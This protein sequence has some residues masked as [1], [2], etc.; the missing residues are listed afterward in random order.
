MVKLHDPWNSNNDFLKIMRTIEFTLVDTK[1]CYF[2]YQLAKS[3]KEGNFCEVGVYRGGSARIL[4]E[5]GRP[6]Y[7]FDT[8]TGLP[9]VL[10]VDTH[11]KK[12]D[13]ADVS[14]EKVKEFLKNFDVKIYQGIF[15][16]TSDP[17]KDKTFSLVHID[18]DIYKS[19]LDCCEFFYPRM[20]PGGIMVFDDYG[21]PG[22][23]GAKKAIDEYFGNK[24]IYIETGQ[25][26]VI[27]D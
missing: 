23:P 22:C 27:K 2:L 19:A 20:L 4:A 10:A 7:L 14:L 21:F 13:F 8:F 9:E 15:P 25:C 11:H 16:N 12:G 17:I 24:V 6:L 1:R 18:V 3:K 5:G 26:F